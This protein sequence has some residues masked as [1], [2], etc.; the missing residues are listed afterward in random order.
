MRLST[1]IRL[2]FRPRIFPLYQHHI[3][4]A[5]SQNSKPQVT[6]S[7]I[8]NCRQCELSVKGV[9]KGAVICHCSNCQKG[10]G[11]AFAHNHRFLPG[12]LQIVKGKD[13]IKQYADSDTKSGNTLYRH[14]CGNCVSR[15]PNYSFLCCR[16][17]V[18]TLCSY[19]DIPQGSP[20]YLTNSAV[21]GLIVLNSGTIQGEKSQPKMDLFPEAKL[22]WVGDLTSKAKL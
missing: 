18:E 19:A 10:S 4:R 16:K 9:D 17:Y 3:Q 1:T 2:I 15:L 14:F 11:S 12:E 13:V 7:S 22:S 6:K 5:M 20:M 8:C 21:K